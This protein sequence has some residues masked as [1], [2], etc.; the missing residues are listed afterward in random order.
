MSRPLVSVYS[1]EKVEGKSLSVQSTVALPDVFLAPI[2]TDIIRTMHTYQRMNLRH[3]HSLFK[4][5]AQ[6]T[7]A[8]SWGTGRAV[9]R[10]PRVTGSGTHRAGQGAFGNM[11]RG[12]RMFA[13]KKLWRRWAHVIKKNEKKYAITGAIA[14][15]GVTA[16]VMAR[17]HRIDRISE[18]P[19]VVSDNVESYDKTKQAVEFLKRVKAMDDVLKVKKILKFVLEKEK[20]EIEELLKKKDLYLYIQKIMV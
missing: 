2:R 9:A 4:F 1:S 3:P 13:P 6:Q 8:E 18:V 20:Q 16:L 7:A 10:I 19:L 11:C 14:A 5:A 15:T 17:G 12:G